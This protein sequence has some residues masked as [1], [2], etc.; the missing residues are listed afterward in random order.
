VLS[1]CRLLAQ[2]Q[3]V[4][5]VKADERFKFVTKRNAERM[6]DITFVLEAGKGL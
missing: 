4:E 6:C 3:E 1:C 5:V 2:G